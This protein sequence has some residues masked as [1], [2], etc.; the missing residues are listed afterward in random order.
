MDFRE[1]GS[2]HLE[3]QI[4]WGIPVTLLLGSAATFVLQSHLHLHN[5]RLQYGLRHLSEAL[6]LAALFVAIAGIVHT[7]L[8]SRIPIRSG[9]LLSTWLR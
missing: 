3:K 9:R 7:F 8:Q 4:F 2:R 1:S 5:L 6:L